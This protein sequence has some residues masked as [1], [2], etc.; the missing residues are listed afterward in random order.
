MNALH[1]VHRGDDVKPHPAQLGA[2]RLQ[3]H[4][5]IIGHQ[6]LLAAHEARR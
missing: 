1:R 6:N 5:V 3:R 4:P 2:E